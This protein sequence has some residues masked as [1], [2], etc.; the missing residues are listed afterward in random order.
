L[1]EPD[2][3]KTPEQFGEYLEARM[4]E[5]GILPQVFCPKKG[6]VLIWHANLIH[7]G[8]PIQDQ[9]LTRK[10]YVTH[11]SSFDAYPPLHKKQEAEKKGFC[12]TENNGYVYDF[13]W[14]TNPNKLP[15]W[16]SK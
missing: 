15:S 7:K 10:S 3:E 14:L 2:S 4:K 6:D 9:R 13:P 8:T 1:Y 16:S 5:F 12:I 11:Y